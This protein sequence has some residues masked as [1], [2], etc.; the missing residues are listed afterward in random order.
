MY[1]DLT[2]SHSYLDQSSQMA[3]E[4]LNLDTS[5]N[6]IGEQLETKE[7]KNKRLDCPQL[8]K[9]SLFHLFTKI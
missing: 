1:K 3:I 9:V 8:L 6:E 4:F 5:L 2:N 7:R